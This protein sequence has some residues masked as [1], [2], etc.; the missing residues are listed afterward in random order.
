MCAPSASIWPKKSS[1]NLLQSRGGSLHLPLLAL[2]QEGMSQVIESAL[3]AIAP[4]AF[5]S[6]PIMI[7]APRVDVVA[8]APGTLQR[9]ILPPQYM[10]VGLTLFGVEE[11]M[12][13]REHWHR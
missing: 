10:N 1:L 6:R 8:L 7:R 12:D 3:A 4:V 2:V 11:L 5:A 13:V 9:A